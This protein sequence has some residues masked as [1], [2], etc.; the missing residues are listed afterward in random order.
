MREVGRS[1]GVLAALVGGAACGQGDLG[2]DPS[3]HAGGAGGVGAVGS[4]GVGASGVGGSS[5]GTGAGGRPTGHGGHVTSAGGAGGATP[6]GG[7]GGAVSGGGAGGATTTCVATTCAAENAICGTIPDGCG[8]TIDCGPCPATS[9]RYVGMFIQ[10]PGFIRPND[11]DHCAKP[12]CGNGCGWPKDKPLA[13]PGGICGADPCQYTTDNAAYW[14]FLFDSAAAMGV[15][16]VI[17]DESNGGQFHAELVGF[18][19][20]ADERLAAGVKTPR[21]TSMSVAADAEWTFQNAATKGGAPRP[22]WMHQDGKPV[23]LVYSAGPFTTAFDDPRFFLRYA[24]NSANDE[25]H[26]AQKEDA[27][28]WPW[29]TEGNAC[30]GFAESCPLYSASSVELTIQNGY[31][32]L[33]PCADYWCQPNCAVLHG[34]TPAYYAAQWAW[35]TA[36]LAGPTQ[37]VVLTTYDNVEGGYLQ[38]SM[39]FNPPT[40]YEDLTTA[41]VA[42]W[43]GETGLRFLGPPGSPCPGAWCRGAPPPVSGKPAGCGFLMPGQSLAPMDKVV[44]CDGRF[45]LI[46]QP[47]G[48]LVLYF[49]GSPLWSKGFGSGAD[50]LTMQPDGNL[51][52]YAGA[53]PVWQAPGTFGHTGAFLAVQPDGNLAVHVGTKLLWQSGT[54]CH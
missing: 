38:R 47:D 7:A 34:F 45:E 6:T 27:R 22:S 8:A 43:K 50:R 26:Q 40:V 52:L 33:L 16:F 53:N 11:P 21:V 9:G 15:D 18:L 4:G 54:C 10:A 49:D 42:G 5:T 12:G 13:P 39:A 2:D 44:S 23:L 51:V 28:I 14:D 41:S 37:V 31:S 35:A 17:A 32:N 46:L 25:C 36:R 24:C 1:W 30:E 3:S 29:A 20:R 48:N 19:D